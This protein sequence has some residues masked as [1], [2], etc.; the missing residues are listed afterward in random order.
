MSFHNY[1]QPIKNLYILYNQS[2][3]FILYINYKK[4]SFNRKILILMKMSVLDVSMFHV[5]M[6]NE[7]ILKSFIIS[8]KISNIMNKFENNLIYNLILLYK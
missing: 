3:F 6:K 4:N 5:K 7:I 8:N 2:K 1:I